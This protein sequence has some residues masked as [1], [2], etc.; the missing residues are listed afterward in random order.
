MILDGWGQNNVISANSLEVNAPG[1]GIWL[2]N[3]AVA[4]G[5]VIRCDNRVAGA[6]P[7]PYATNQ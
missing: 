1:A 5:N 2:Q 3:A 7:E 4:L 6:T